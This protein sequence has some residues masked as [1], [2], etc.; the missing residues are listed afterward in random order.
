MCTVSTNGIANNDL[1]AKSAKPVKPE[2]SGG[3]LQIVLVGG[4]AQSV[5][6]LQPL[7]EQ[8]ASLGNVHP[9]ILNRCEACLQS[10]IASIIRGFSGQSLLV[11]WSL[12]GQ[13]LLRTFSRSTTQI[14]LK[15]IKHKL[16]GKV[17]IASNPFFIGDR[18]WPGVGEA[19]FGQFQQ[20][21][22]S[23]PERLLNKFY[24]LQLLGSPDYR[25]LRQALAPALQE[26]R[27][28]AADF[29]AE[30]LNWLRQW[31]CRA[32]LQEH[33]DGVFYFGKQDRLVPRQLIATLSKEIPAQRIIQLQDMAHYPDAGAA[34]H[35]TRKYQE[36]SWL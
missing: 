4:W 34:M 18:Q 25:L 27:C 3:Q 15:A 29:L 12:G 21:L 1:S 23:D 8:L 11:G 24:N 7:A 30:S 17:F 16:A 10:Q 14:D 20:E 32:L 22:V 36:R 6:A 19:V 13:L 5:P 31:D 33:T 2:N 28:I 26:S 9:V 35:I